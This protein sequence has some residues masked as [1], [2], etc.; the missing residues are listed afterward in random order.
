[1]RPPFPY[2]GGKMS[3]ADRIVALLPPHQSYV[4]PCFGSGAVLLAKP[5]SRMETVGDIDERLMAFWR[6]LRD[7]PD[8][9]KQWGTHG[10]GRALDGRIHDEYPEDLTGRDSRPGTTQTPAGDSAVT[11]PGPEAG[12]GELETPAPSNTHAC[13]CGCGRQIK[14]SLLVCV[15]GGKLLPDDLREWIVFS[16]QARYGRDPRARR[17]DDQQSE[18]AVEANRAAIAAAKT[19]WV[20][21]QQAARFASRRCSC[22]EQ[23]VECS[24]RAGSGVLVDAAPVLTSSGCADCTIRERAGRKPLVTT[25]SQS[26]LFGADWAWRMH[27]CPAAARTSRKRAA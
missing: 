5:P 19:W 23:V 2:F 24:D 6:V 27:A 22:G 10:A 21:R 13:P 18:W 16:Q 4:E 12:G 20:M 3:L 17:P 9:F 25:A 15:A 7:R 26:D 14:A 1:M 11:T 8:E